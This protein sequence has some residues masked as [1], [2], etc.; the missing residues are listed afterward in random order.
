MAGQ[1]CLYYESSSPHPPS[2][3]T[4][5]CIFSEW[6]STTSIANP[7]MRKETK[8]LTAPSLVLLSSC[9]DAKRGNP[10][11]WWFCKSFSRHNH[12]RQARGHK[13]RVGPEICIQI[14]ICTTGQTELAPHTVLLAS[15]GCIKHI[16]QQ[17]QTCVHIITHRN[18]EGI[19]ALSH[20]TPP[21]SKAT[22]CFNSY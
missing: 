19:D 14:L 11:C 9:F 6:M 8:I 17:G 10:G 1:C 22:P 18:A 20:L 2:T 7:R 13:K 12:L 4:I 5:T 16:R 15:P 21:L 3:L